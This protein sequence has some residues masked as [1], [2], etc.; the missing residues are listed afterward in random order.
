MLV[1]RGD[2]VGRD[3]APVLASAITMPWKMS[4]SGAATT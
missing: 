3:K 1:Q 2:L 4:S